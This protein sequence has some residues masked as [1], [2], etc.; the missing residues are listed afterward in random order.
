MT[1]A[2]VQLPQ[3]RA[4]ALALAYRRAT[5]ARRNRGLAG[6]AVLAACILAS[7]YFGEVDFANF[8]SHIDNFTNY[9]GR[10]FFLDGGA[11]VFSDPAEWFWGITQ[12][13][14]WL[15]LLGETLMIA[16]LGTL[17]GAVGG[18]AWSFISA[19]NLAPNPWLR[20]FAKR[21]L[22]ICRSVPEL[23]YAMIFVVA[24][25]LG[26]L[27]GVLALAIHSTGALGKLFAEV[28]EN[29][30]MKPV[31]GLRS[32]GAGWLQTVRFAAVPQVL[33]NF[34]SYTLL[35]FEINVREA[36]IMG[37]VGAGG[38]GQELLINVR[39]F[40]YSDVSAVLLLIIATVVVIDL[41][42]ERIRYALIGGQERR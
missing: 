22:E 6:L 1:S 20:V 36:G 21:F 34:A 17:I 40:Y 23:V 26:P 25:G 11:S 9:L 16:Y 4:E 15:P 42:T 28:V 7:G 31:E 33:S 3:P 32:T 41:V 38:I 29:I 30:D 12:K 8:F 18:F 2:I 24:F 27:P 35:R 10:L 19:A 39:K 13:N 37:F 5:E 14:K